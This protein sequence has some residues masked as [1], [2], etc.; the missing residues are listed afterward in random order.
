MPFGFYANLDQYIDFSASC[1]FAT[2]VSDPQAAKLHRALSRSGKILA[3]LRLKSCVIFDSKII[4][5]D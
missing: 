3:N 4:V 1:W 2:N 5:F